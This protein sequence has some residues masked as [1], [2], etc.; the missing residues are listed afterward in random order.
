MFNGFTTEVTANRWM[1]GKPQI[2]YKH[3]DPKKL[4]D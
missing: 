2:F 4:K 3:S 1:D